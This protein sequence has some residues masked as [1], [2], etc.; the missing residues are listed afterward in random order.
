[1]YNS[2]DKNREGLKSITKA[3]NP[4]LGTPKHFRVGKKG[5]FG[6]IETGR[7]KH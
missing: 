4:I 6:C 2:L 1:M 7:R 3:E 5:L